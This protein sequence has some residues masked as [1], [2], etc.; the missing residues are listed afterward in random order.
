MADPPLSDR[1]DVLL[2]WWDRDLSIDFTVVEGEVRRILGEHG[3]WLRQHDGDLVQINFS[4]PRSDASA[5][6]LGL[7][8]RKRDG[9]LTEDHFLCT[10]TAD[11]LKID[12]YYRGDLERALREYL[13]T[14]KEQPDLTTA[15][16]SPWPDGVD[17]DPRT[18]TFTKPIK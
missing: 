11:G 10:Q 6:V 17:T 5:L 3:I 4:V 9:S 7:R 15:L 18:I 14:H 12:S 1:F 16:P 8:Y 2:A 13:G